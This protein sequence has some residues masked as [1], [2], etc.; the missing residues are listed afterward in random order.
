M[1]NVRIFTSPDVGNF[2]FNK[3][4]DIFHLNTEDD[5]YGINYKFTDG[6]DYTHAI[7]LNTAMPVLKNIPK[8]NVIGLACEPMAFLRL[9]RQFI[10]YAVKNIGKYI[11]GDPFESLIEP[12]VCDFPY[13]PEHTV[14]FLTDVVHNDKPKLMSIMVSNKTFAPGHKY[15]HVLVQEIVKRGLP[16]DI[17]GRGCKYYKDSQMDPRFKG[18]F[19]Q[20]SDILYKDY[21]FHI[22]I[23]NFSCEHYL[24]EKIKNPLLCGTV[25]I[26]WGCRNIEQY[27]PGQYISLSGNLVHDI[28]ML[29]DICSEPEKYLKVID[30]EKVRETISIKNLIKQQWL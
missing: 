2:H 18:E 1:I 9:S 17:Y 21:K 3:M 26:Y 13:M 16:I 14:P 23:E 7:L 25:P 8:E 29:S 12:F 5:K 27:F 30:I 22:A 11:L 24:S 19:E 15:R 28:Q 10:N 20:G 4:I 6:D